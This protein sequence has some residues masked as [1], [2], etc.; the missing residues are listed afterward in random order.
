MKK[1]LWI[2]KDYTDP[3]LNDFLAKLIKK[4]ILKVPVAYSS[5]VMAV[6]IICLDEGRHLCQAFPVNKFPGNQGIL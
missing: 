3:P 4:L 5:C 6:L 2:Y 1:T